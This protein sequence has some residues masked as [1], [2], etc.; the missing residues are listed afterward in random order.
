MQ[1]ALQKAWEVA[2]LVVEKSP[3]FYFVNSYYAQPSHSAMT[4]GSTEYGK[5][6]ASM[7]WHQNICA[8]QF[9]LEK[10]GPSG[11]ALLR[12]LLQVGLKSANNNNNNRL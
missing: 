4:V 5:K 8:T 2:F 6:F 9:H 3:Y 11:L 1:N 10:S 12:F 7:I